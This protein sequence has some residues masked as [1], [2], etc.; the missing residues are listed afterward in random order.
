MHDFLAV[1]PSWLQSLLL[2][3]CPLFDLHSRLCRFSVLSFMGLAIWS[4]W[5]SQ[6]NYRDFKGK[7]ILAYC[8]P[9]SLYTSHSA[10]LDWQCYF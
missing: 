10:T 6:A 8:F 7:D 9:K 3:F 4:Y 1:L 5:F 2:L